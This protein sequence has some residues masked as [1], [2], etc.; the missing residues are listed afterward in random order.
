MSD[1]IQTVAK[2][3]P[4]VG[5][6]LG[7]PFGGAIGT[8]IA[9]AFNADPADEKEIINKINNDPDAK[10]K[11]IT[12]EGEIKLESEKLQ[13]EMAQAVLTDNRE[14]ET[15]A[16]EDRKS[17]RGREQE[18]KDKMPMIL[19]IGI[20]VIYAVI[21]L[22]VLSHEDANDNI[23]GRVQDLIIYVVG[24]YFGSSVGSR[25]KDDTINKMK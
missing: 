3:A 20:L 10:F 5:T 15:I 21:Q 9:T 8:L 16:Y 1:L 13:N 19:G 24:Y 14:R 6:A 23:S 11:L 7:G 22:Y 12:L 4:V 18:V 2:F 17:A 25:R